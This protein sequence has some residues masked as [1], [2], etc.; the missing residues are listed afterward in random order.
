MVK[1]MMERIYHRLYEDLLTSQFD[2]PVYQH[3]LSHF[4]LGKSYRDEE[5]RVTA[6]PDDIVVDYIAS[7]TD[8]YFIDLYAYLFP[9]D[10]FNQKVRYI[11][12]F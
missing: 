9:D 5:Y 6:D 11:P 7:M 12:Y 3:H 8:D 10:P 4:I 1:P 2:S